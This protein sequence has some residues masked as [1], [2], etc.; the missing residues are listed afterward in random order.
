MNFF[1]TVCRNIKAYKTAS[2][3]NF[4][5]LIT[6]FTVFVLIMLYVHTE[7]R[8]DTYHQDYK[9]IYRLELK[10]PGKSKNSV[11]MSGL[12][13]DVIQEQLPEVV[14]T[15]VYMPWGK[16]GEILFEW[17]QEG[18]KKKGYND[19]AISDKH[20]TDVFTFD[21]IHAASDEPLAEPN[22]VMVSDAFARKLWGTTEVMDKTLKVALIVAP[23]ADN[24]QNEYRVTAVFRTPPKN[25]IFNEP[26]IFSFPTTGWLEVA[27]RSWGTEN[28]PEFIKVRPGTDHSLLQSSISSIDILKEKYNYHD[29]GSERSDV[30]ARPLSELRFAKD[31]AEN[32]LFKTNNRA[33]VNILLIVG[34]F[35]LVIAVLNYINFATAMLPKRMKNIGVSRILGSSRRR[36]VTLHIAEAL[37]FFT[38][39][40]VIGI[41]LAAVVNRHFGTGLF[42][43]RLDFTLC[44]V[45]LLLMALVAILS[46]MVAGTIPALG[47]MAITPA[48]T[49][50]RKYALARSSSRGWL[51][52]VQFAATIALVATSALTI[53]QVN[54]MKNRPL[55]FDKENRM[56]IVPTD[57]LLENLD[58][59]KLALQNSPLIEA[60][61]LSSGVPGV[62]SNVEGFRFNDEIYQ[63]WLWNVDD[64]YVKMMDF[65]LIEGRHFLSH[66][67]A[68]QNS[69][70][71]NETAK[72]QFGLELGSHI[73]KG[74][75][76]GN[77][78]YYQVVGI[79]KDFNFASLRESVDPFTF[80]YLPG[81]FYGYMNVKLAT[82]DVK[83]TVDFVTQEYNKLS[84]N[85]PIRYYFL[86]EQLNLLYD[87]ED[88]VIGMIAMFSLLSLVVSVLG[89]LGLSIFTAQYRTKEIGIRKVNGAS[90][91]EIVRM[92]NRNVVIWL[93]I[94]FV[95]ATPIAYWAMS[96]WL[97]NF[98][99]K[100]TLSWWIFA[101]AGLTAL[102]VALLTVSWQSLRAATRNPVE[103]LKYE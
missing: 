47:S 102:V 23:M 76:E 88:R 72:R 70:I 50:K 36:V 46:G 85:E 24:E 57:D 73:M 100:T 79:I 38:V 94:A 39:S 60:T 6:A 91:S 40:F 97:E 11:Y 10:T 44:I 74:D 9:D 14:A 26:A 101:L 27:Y 19:Y 7:Y 84:P 48:D 77:P 5:G 1:K 13:K 71:I 45:P 82:N 29:K 96:R 21:F 81:A 103:A 75:A 66:S 92:L 30:I 98:A 56:V 52:V 69:I 83:S 41:A 49:V 78:I 37:L 80:R 90:V 17:E 43:Y 64:K 59:F 93:G 31:I 32:P 61:A 68:E 34:I 28:F 58:A 99:Y 62:P 3:F 18:E 65:E 16:W 4:I 87:K 20:L 22:S 12:T 63:T 55:G 95:I 53:K 2:V 15:T 51:T 86:D 67:E 54:F 89:V 35:I 25:S 33:S 42:E 8:F